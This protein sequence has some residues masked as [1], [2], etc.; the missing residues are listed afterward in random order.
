MA[1]DPS[2]PVCEMEEHSPFV[3]LFFE[4]RET[5]ACF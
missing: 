5:K 1:V 2:P 4:V 3:S